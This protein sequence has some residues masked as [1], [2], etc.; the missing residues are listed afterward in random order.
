MLA[1]DG[2]EADI[3]RPTASNA[4]AD[5]AYQVNQSTQNIG[6]RRLYTILERLLED[7]SFKAPEPK[8]KTVAI[9]ATYVHKQLDAIRQDEDLRKFI[10]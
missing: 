7:I 5:I 10:L 8:K 1:A 2:V 6:A 4:L 3:S 9:D